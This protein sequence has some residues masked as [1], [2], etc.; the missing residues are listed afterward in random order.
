MIF[1]QIGNDTIQG[2]GSVSIP[3]A[4]AR[5]VRTSARRHSVAR[6]QTDGNDYV[7]GGRQRP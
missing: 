6:P 5:H 2:D 4:D 1:G 7:E 3:L